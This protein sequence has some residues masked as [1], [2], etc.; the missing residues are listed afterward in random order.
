MVYVAKLFEVT[1]FMK[2][3]D[4]RLCFTDEVNQILISREGGKF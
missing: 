3:N 2:A 1:A 4:K